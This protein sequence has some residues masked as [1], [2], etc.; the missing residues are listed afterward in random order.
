MILPRKTHVDSY[1][2]LRLILRHARKFELDID[3]DSPAALSR[4]RDLTAQKESWPAKLFLHLDVENA[5]GLFERLSV[6]D[7]TGGFLSIWKM[8][9]DQHRDP[10]LSCGDV[11]IVRYLL[12]SKSKKNGAD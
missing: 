11:E 3:D 9:L 1:Q 10:K 8:V 2:L 4:L 12:L 6:A 7:L 5:T